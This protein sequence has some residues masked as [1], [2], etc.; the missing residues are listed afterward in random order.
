MSVFGAYMDKLI[1]TNAPGEAFILG[2]ADNVTPEAKI[3]RVR[4]ITELV[5]Q[6]GSY[7]L[8]NTA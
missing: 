1:E 2:A 7:P 8:R 5:E 6:R 3:E 4:W